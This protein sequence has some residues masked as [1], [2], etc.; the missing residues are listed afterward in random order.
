M[1]LR[2][3]PSLELPYVAGEALKRKIE[4]KR[5]DY[6]GVKP[7]SSEAKP[8]DTGGQRLRFK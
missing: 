3:D 5:K 1:Q 4:K 8:I 2:F 7:K 6:T